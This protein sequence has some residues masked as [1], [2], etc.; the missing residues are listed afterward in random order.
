MS[1]LPSTSDQAVSSFWNRYIDALHSH[2]VYQR[3]VRWHVVWA[4]RYIKAFPNQRLQ[5]HTAKHVAKF[6]DG[7]CRR[8]LKDWQ[9]RQAAESIRI[10]LDM[11]GASWSRDLDWDRWRG[12]AP[13]HEHPEQDRGPS[14]NTGRQAGPRWEHAGEDALD[15]VRKRYHREFTALV[16]EV[17]Q[18]AYSLRTE[19]AYES[20]LARFILHSGGKNPRTLDKSHIVSF[21]Q[22]LAVDRNVAAS[23]QNQALNALVFFFE[24]VLKRKVGEMEGFVRA[25]R[26]KRLPTVLSK[27]EVSALLQQ[28][29]GTKWLMASLLYGTG[30]RLMECIRLR[31]QDVDFEYRQILVR[32]GKGKKDRVVPMPAALVAPLQEQLEEGY[33]IHQNDLRNGFGE[34]YLPYA[35]ARKYPNA[36]RE[37]KWQ[38]VFYSARISTDPRSGAVR[39]HHVHE[40]SLQKGIKVAARKAGIT[41]RVNCHALRHSFAT[42]LLEAGYDIRTVQE[43]L[44]H[45]DVS[46]TMIYTHVLN[47]GGRGVVSPLDGL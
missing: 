19:Q 9:I 42:H 45:A 3:Y 27:S 10:L 22:Y 37:W 46:T 1:G 17:R 14:T 35:L 36:G 4:E 43:L 16:T 13:P 26:P 41:K 25:K 34:V 8:R 2:G 7:L 40:N 33:Q 11:T 32:N 6:L 5:S 30:M 20:W 28:M 18:R 39:R 24:Q 23:T 47:R 21:L 44:G 38:Y 29:Q 15:V 31:V 12:E